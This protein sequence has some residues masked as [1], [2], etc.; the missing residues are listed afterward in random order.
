MKKEFGK[1]FLDLAKYILT[2]IFLTTYLT[3]LEE[4]RLFWITFVA[5][6]LCLLSGYFLLKQSD[7]EN[8]QAS[9]TKSTTNSVETME[10]QTSLPK[11][12][13]SKSTKHKKK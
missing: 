4:S 9:E 7:K 2:A 5:F 11:V 1:W 10:E 13:T 6:V 8:I 3:G 12:K